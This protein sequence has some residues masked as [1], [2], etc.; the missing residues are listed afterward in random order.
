MAE[1]KQVQ[2][3][4]P[5]AKAL[6]EMQA[7]RVTDEDCEILSVF[8]NDSNLNLA[9]RNAFMGFELTSIEKSLLENRLVPSVKKVLRKMFLPE[10]EPEIAMGQNI[11]LW[12]TNDIA[13]AEPENFDTVYATKFKLIEMI[14]IGLGRLDALDDE[15]VD[16]TPTKDLAFLKAR[17]NLIN[18]VTM[19]IQ[20]IVMNANRPIK[21]MS[22]EETLKKIKANSSK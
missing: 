17:V 19:T 15:G 7:P 12:M 3:N 8:K 21:G 2:P 13:G 10:L 16:L 20:D 9:L 6:S 11:D 18:H 1:Q 22:A 14:E 4:S 5:Q